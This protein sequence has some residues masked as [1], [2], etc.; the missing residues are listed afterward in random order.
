MYPEVCQN[1]MLQ[2]MHFILCG[3]NSGRLV[4]HSCSFSVGKN[5]AEIELLSQKITKTTAKTAGI[6]H[7]LVS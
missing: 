4:E 3:Q 1:Y 2:I 6:Q 5:V 7:D